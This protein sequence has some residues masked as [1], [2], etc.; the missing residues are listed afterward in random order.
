MSPRVR[1][2]LL[3]VPGAILVGA[4]LYLFWDATQLP[5]WVGVLFF[6]FWVGKDVVLYPLLRRAYES[7]DAGGA[8]ALVGRHGTAR[9]ALDPDGQVQVEGELWRARAVE[10]AAPIPEGAEVV[11]RGADRFTLLVER[12]S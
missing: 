12:A 9:A 1:Y 2:A 11:V 3:Q 5:R 8:E 7:G 10:G 6:V 4:G